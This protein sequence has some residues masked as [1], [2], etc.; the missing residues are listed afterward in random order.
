MPTETSSAGTTRTQTEVETTTGRPIPYADQYETV[1]NVVADANAN[2]NAE[3]SINSLLE[4]H[5]GDDALLYF[6]PG[7]YLMDDVWLYDTFANFGLV[8]TDA[9]IVPKRGYDDYLFVLG[10]P[11]AGS[12]GLL[13]EGFEFDFR[14]PETRPRP[15]QVQVDDGLSVRNVTVLGSSGT[16]RFDV[17]TADG[18]GRVRE[19]TLPDGGSDPHPTGVLVSPDNVGRLTFENCHVEGFPDNGLYASPS[20]GPVHVL[21]GYYANNGI[22][23]VRVSDPAVVRDVRVRCDRA[24]DGFRNM[25]GIRLRHGE[26][27]LVENCTV[28]MHDVTYSEGAVVVESQMKSPTIRDVS[29]E[30]SVDDVMAINAKSPTDAGAGTGTDTGTGTGTKP[31]IECENVSVTGTAGKGSTIRVVDRDDCSFHA[32]DVEQT[33]ADRDGLYLIRS[34]DAVLSDATIDVTGEPIVLEQSDVSKRNVDT[35]QQGGGESPRSLPKNS[36][37]LQIKERP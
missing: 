26:S 21:G 10:L 7:R 29:I 13:F 15:V 25:R 23:N 5:A 27:V 6:P 4:R 11:D 20:K 2:P 32:L 36:R 18:S 37:H 16:A 28:E 8:G 34:N 19:L 9:T 1:V 22:S 24:P 31:A 12:S 17:T 35:G 3:R 14:A 33:G 30:L